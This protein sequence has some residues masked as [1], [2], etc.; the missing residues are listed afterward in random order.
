MARKKKE[1]VI[2]EVKVIP[3][4]KTQEQKK[5]DIEVVK[6]EINKNINNLRPLRLLR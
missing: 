3:E 6:R 5:N 4:Q 2:E 1:V